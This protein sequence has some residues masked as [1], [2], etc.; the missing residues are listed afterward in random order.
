MAQPQK[1]WT[2]EWVRA[3]QIYVALIHAT[4]MVGAGIFLIARIFDLIQ[5]LPLRM[6]VISWIGGVTALLG[7]TLALPQR[8]LKKGLA[9]LYLLCALKSV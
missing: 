2:C 3:G 5:L 6:N 8:D 4:I 9:Y 1:S 7:S